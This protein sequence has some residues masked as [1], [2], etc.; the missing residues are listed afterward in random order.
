MGTRRCKT[1]QQTFGNLA[2]VTYQSDDGGFIW[3]RWM[4]WAS[5][6]FQPRHLLYPPNYAKAPAHAETMMGLAWNGSNQT[7]NQCD[8]CPSPHAYSE[9]VVRCWALHRC[10]A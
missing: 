7:V 5:I 10:G 6:I 9:F 3:Q 8:G 4:L 1:M 2:S